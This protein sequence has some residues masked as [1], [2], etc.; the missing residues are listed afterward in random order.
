[1]C[2]L[3]RNRCHVIENSRSENLKKISEQH[4]WWIFSKVSAEAA[5]VR[6]SGEKLSEK[7]GKFPGKNPC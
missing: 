2:S 4:A 3:K 6:C 7:F 1:M 5:I